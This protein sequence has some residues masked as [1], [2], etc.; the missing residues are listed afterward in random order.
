[1]VTHMSLS[2]NQAARRPERDGSPGVD[3]EY[4]TIRLAL[5]VIVMGCMSAFQVLEL[6]ARCRGA[7]DQP[8]AGMFLF[9]T[10]SALIFVAPVV[11][12]ATAP[13][14]L[15]TGRLARFLDGARWRMPALAALV[16]PAPTAALCWGFDVPGA[17]IAPLG[18]YVWAGLVVMALLTRLSKRRVGAGRQPRLISKVY[19]FGGL[20]VALVSVVGEM[21]L[22]V[23]A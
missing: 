4:R 13:L 22:A 18:V 1:M 8:G 2:E 7:A 3:T 5:A 14:I 6:I 11:L 21:N 19:G 12:F 15:A 10:V 16:A 9:E 23:G 20:V 17:A